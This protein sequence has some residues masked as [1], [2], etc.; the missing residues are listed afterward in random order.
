MCLSEVGAEILKKLHF[1][2]KNVEKWLL[3]GPIGKIARPAKV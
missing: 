1:G 2:F 3:R